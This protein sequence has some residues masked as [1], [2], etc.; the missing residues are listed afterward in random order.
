MTAYARFAASPIAAALQV[1]DGG[2]SLTSNAAS[3]LTGKARSDIPLGAGTRGVEFTFWGENALQATIGLCTPAA[4]ADAEVGA[5]GG[6]GWRLHSGEVV[7]AGVVVAGLPAIAKGDVVG[8]RVQLDSPRTVAFY[9]NGDQVYS[10]ALGL[11]GALHFAVSL[12][13]TA[14]GGLHCIVNAGQ[15]QGFAPATAGW[16][17][18]MASMPPLHLAAEDYMSAPGDTP[19]NQPYLGCVAD[20][21]L[22]AVASVSFW[23]W[24]SSSR[25]GT[26]ALRLLDAEGLL[27][28]VALGDV[29]DVPVQVRQ[30]QQGQPLASADAVSRFVLERIDI[31]DDGRKT[32]VLRDPHDD[33][34]APLHRAVFLPS[35]NDQLAW[36]PQP[37]VIGAVRSLPCIAVN[38]DGSVQWLCDSPL[39][40]V[41][42]VV[43]RGAEILA[44][45]GYALVAGGQQLSFDS[46]PVGPVLVDASSIGAGMQPATLEQALKEVFRRI[47]KA[48]WAAAD[49]TAIDVATGYAGVGYYAGE[50]GT[51]REA[52]AALLASYTADWWQDGDGVL[53]VARLIDPDTVADGDLAF[54]LDWR[55]LRGD[56]VVTPD[57]APN[58]SRRMAYQPN[59]RPLASGDMIT[60]M[61][62]LPPAVRQQLT[63]E[64]RGQVY[65]GG[66][67]AARYIRAEAAAPMPSRFDQR[68]DAQAEI[69]RVVGLYAIPRHFY[70]GTLAGRTDLT[71]RPGQIGRITYP[72][73]GLQA[74]RKVL[75]TSVVGN[76]V[77]GRHIIRFWGA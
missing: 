11:P 55:E 35:I 75:V 30:V 29:R 22:D 17:L 70:S 62:Q 9:R 8:V 14:A 44:G 59:A 46:P 38:S 52:L 16:A 25:A 67:L 10:A 43:D 48:A 69:D 49:A 13:S 3:T 36:Q 51:P 73:Y 56:L 45:D 41:A 42:R 64:Y 28:T 15:W 50:G 57:L 33:L 5:A 27:D 31:E 72:R 37:V 54:D 40:S 21:G 76:P 12:A 58:L 53:R 61:E 18:P 66:P 26:A 1:N 4:A 34:D 24:A 7:S 23:P 32:A 19:A 39:A 60:D 47:D 71:F 2:L 74:G 77:T 20:S 65:A 6:I 63:G 68:A